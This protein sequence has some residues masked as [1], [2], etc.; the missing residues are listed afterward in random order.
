VL[1]LVAKP[2]PVLVQ[3]AAEVEDPVLTD[4]LQ[5]W[6]DEHAQN[7]KDSRRRW[8]QVASHLE[9]FHPGLRISQLTKA[10]YI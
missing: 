3:P 10:F 9:A 2:Q 1:S 8:Q 6:K 4:L 5:Q 7:S